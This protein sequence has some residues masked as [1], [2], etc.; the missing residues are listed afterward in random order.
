MSKKCIED[1]LSSYID[2]CINGKEINHQSQSQVDHELF[3]LGKILADK[4]FSKGSNK[5]AV[6]DKTL[7]NINENKGEKM[8]RKLNI[9]KRSV[10]AASL[11]VVGIMSVFLIQPSFA[12]NLVGKIINTLSLGHVRIIQTEPSH[13]ENGGKIS[14]PDDLKGKI[15]DK[16]G[17][18]IEVYSDK[19]E[20][21]RYYTADGEE[22]AY[23][24]DG[25]II[26]V[27]EKEKMAQE[28]KLVVK[29]PNE[30]EKYTCFKVILPSYLPEGY[31][32]DRAEF[33]K[34]EKGVVSPK[35][36]DLYFINESTGN[37]IY[38]QQRFAD[39][40]TAFETGT[41]REIEQVMINDVDAVIIDARSMHWETNH[42]I[43]SLS[44]RGQ[45]TNSELIKIA[46]SI[47]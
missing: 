32:F 44:G 28:H 21:K 20:Q 30:L 37:S 24:S 43:Y 1:Q 8:M 16:E 27:S 31:Q 33:Y 6:F 41:E 17:N 29:E 14:V 12:H 22:I 18:P 26:T 2:D 25:E 34:D 40:E 42:V 5:K 23:V 3:E 36:M 7:V 9:R 15:F 47:Q 38:M 35:Y 19:S 13:Q 10:V 4:D 46:E 39:E 11:L 45:I